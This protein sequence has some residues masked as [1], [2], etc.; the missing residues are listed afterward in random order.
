VLYI[1]PAPVATSQPYPFRTSI[2]VLKVITNILRIERLQISS[3]I[4]IR[5]F[6]VLFGVKDTPWEDHDWFGPELEDLRTA[7]LKEKVIP[8]SLFM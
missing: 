6:D 7:K 2:D 3:F 5:L 1:T 4:N 8:H